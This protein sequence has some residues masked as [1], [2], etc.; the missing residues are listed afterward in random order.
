MAR[1]VLTP[2]NSYSVTKSKHTKCED[3]NFN[4]ELR[5]SLLRQLRLTTIAGARLCLFRLESLELKIGYDLLKE[6]VL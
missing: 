4:V 1:P 2:E 6:M 5:W 3:T